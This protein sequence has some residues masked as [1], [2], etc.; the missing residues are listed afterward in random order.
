[1]F[2][3]VPKRL[4]HI[5]TADEDSDVTLGLHGDPISPA[6]PLRQ[7]SLFYT[8][9]NL[10]NDMLADDGENIV[11]EI[12]T[13]DEANF[14]NL[15]FEKFQR[16]E[17][18]FELLD[19]DYADLGEFPGSEGLSS[20]EPSDPERTKSVT[21]QPAYQMFQNG[22]K[23]R[24]ENRLSQTVVHE[25]RGFSV[26]SMLFVLLLALIPMVL[27]QGVTFRGE[28]P[29]ETMGDIA[30]RF[31][32]ID[33]RIDALASVSKTLSSTNQYLSSSV[34]TLESKLD[35]ASKEWTA[36]YSLIHQ[37]FGITEIQCIRDKLTELQ[38]I[39]SQDSLVDYSLEVESMTSSIATLVGQVD[40]L[41]LVV[42]MLVSAEH[43]ALDGIAQRLPSEIPLIVSK[44]D[45]D[46]KLL[47]EFE[48]FLTKLISQV[49]QGNSSVSWDQF[50]KENNSNMLLYIREITSNELQY[51]T[52]PALTEL[53][54]LKLKT[55]NEKLKQE[56]SKLLT[57][58]LEKHHSTSHLD[59]QELSSKIEVLILENMVA[60]FRNES[61]PSIAYLRNFAS[62]EHGARILGFLTSPSIFKAERSLLGKAFLG[63]YDF[64]TA[65]YK[66]GA[67]NVLL[68][69]TSLAETERLWITRLE[70]AHLGIKLTEN[71]FF[72]ELVLETQ[73]ISD[74]L[75]RMS[76]P[77][78]MS[79]F[80]RPLEA[81]KVGILREEFS[82]LA[83]HNIRP[84][85][86]FTK[87][88]EME[89]SLRHKDPFQLFK[90]PERYLNLGIPIKDIYIEFDNNWG[91]K[92]ILCVGGIKVF[93]VTSVELFSNSEKLMKWMG[94]NSDQLL[95]YIK[96]HETPK[97]TTK[98]VTYSNIGEDEEL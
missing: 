43:N 71:I 1:M 89:Y 84:L 14:L 58:F 78:K 5:E 73:D 41:N 81:S 52:M 42:L 35:A 94:K 32:V 62:Y 82:D 33:N 26:W 29:L 95:S 16:N 9:S 96:Q 54:A 51:I 90:T 15:N 8:R 59:E 24:V 65:D 25:V 28:L 61:A 46:F 37:N 47:P 18:V 48:L 66:S 79:L 21:L 87:I 13:D 36:S 2:A 4:P 67:N 93:G 69:Y 20:A 64:F 3:K 40:H 74:V 92:E 11:S 45:Q 88:M 31:R 44:N 27:Y 53:L 50:M 22:E 98:P 56:I 10:T 30:N 60:A 83:Q 75:Y 6:K 17:Q 55:N 49:S 7:K 39:I 38:E 97:V 70:G 76:L 85:N 57:S 77:Q 12:I 34:K 80:V 91:N 68:D 19:D 23:K 72:T 63:W 86:S